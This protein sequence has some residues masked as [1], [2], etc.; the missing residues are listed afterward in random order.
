MSL[1]KREIHSTTRD[2]ESVL[3]P[4]RS[5]AP[6]FNLTQQNSSISD[7]GV[8]HFRGTS[9]KVNHFKM[10]NVNSFWNFQNPEEMNATISYISADDGGGQTNHGQRNIT[11]PT[12]HTHHL[13]V[14]DFFQRNDLAAHSIFDVDNPYSKAFQLLLPFDVPDNEHNV[15]EMRVMANN[16][17]QA[18]GLT[19]TNEDDKIYEHESDVILYR[20]PARHISLFYK[21]GNTGDPDWHIGDFNT[22][23]N[24]Y[25][26]H[27]TQETIRQGLHPM[28][29]T[30][31]LEIHA[32]DTYSG[33]PIPKTELG[34]GTRINLHT[35]MTYL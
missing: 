25:S 33:L 22:E 31:N 1:T 27:F 13:K 11:I 12:D 14:A 5:E 9:Q 2:R 18:F 30:R 16:T 21:T 10:S 19:T 8:F 6:H 35:Q 34:A 26:H 29:K 15:S 3:D 32:R 23:E 28:T 17:T 4:L 24:P 7:D 20:Q